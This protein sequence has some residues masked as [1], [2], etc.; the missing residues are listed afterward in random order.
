MFT[1]TGGRTTQFVWG[2]ACGCPTS[3]EGAEEEG[4]ERANREV[5]HRADR[6]AARESRVLDVDGAQLAILAQLR[7]EDERDDRRA[8]ER[9][10]RVDQ[11]DLLL[12]GADAALG[13]G[14]RRRQYTQRNVVPIIAV[15]SELRRRMLPACT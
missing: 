4:A 6:D 15:R 3:S 13:G 11:R 10:D 8:E 7:R 14:E 5:D 9:E 12:L 1:R 2:G